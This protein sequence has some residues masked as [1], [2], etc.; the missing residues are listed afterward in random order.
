MPARS[1]STNPWRWGAASVT[2]T[3]QRQRR[4]PVEAVSQQP[5]GTALV[6]SGARP[7]E[8]IGSRR[9]GRCPAF[10]PTPALGDS[11]V[12][13]PGDPG[14]TGAD[15]APPAGG[16]PGRRGR[17]LGAVRRRPGH[18]AVRPGGAGRGGRRCGSGSPRCCWRSRPGR[19]SGFDPAPG[20]GGGGGLRAGPGRH[21]P[22]LLRGHRPHPARR[23][24]DHRVLRAAGPGLV[25]VPALA[26]PG[27]GRSWRGRGWRCSRPAGAA[28]SIRSG[29][30]SPS[31]PGSA[32]SATSCSASRPD[33][34]S[35]PGPDWASPW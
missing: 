2:W 33:A 30:P 1:V 27:L 9:G 13:S 14:R 3:T 23:G 7:P 24:G 6:L 12:A 17:L 29:S 21:E 19:G 25:R 34:G 11:A 20:P 5:A 8:R 4:L 22:V 28:T 16:R 15:A 18:P 32:G 26:R 31:W 35:T 10:R